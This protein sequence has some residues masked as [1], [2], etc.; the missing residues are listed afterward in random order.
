MPAI[1]GHMEWGS[2]FVYWFSFS[3]CREV[4][5]TWWCLLEL[6]RIFGSDYSVS[7]IY[8]SSD[9]DTLLLPL[10]RIFGSDCLQL[11]HLRIFGFYFDSSATTSDFGSDYSTSTSSDIRLCYFHPLLHWIFGSELHPS[12]LSPDLR[13]R[14]LKRKILRMH[15]NFGYFYSASSDIVCWRAVDYPDT[16]E[17]FIRILLYFLIGS[18]QEDI[19]LYLLWILIVT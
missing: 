4:V 1:I 3:G 7:Y 11:L 12:T 8:G 17:Y 18:T 5:C 16:S 10:L 9:S 19:R 15:W 13:H 2:H 14:S 6:L